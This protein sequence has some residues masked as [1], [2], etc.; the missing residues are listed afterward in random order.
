[1]RL[2]WQ[3]KAETARPTLGCAKV[4]RHQRRK[5]CQ[6]WGSSCAR[7][8]AVALF[9]SATCTAGGAGGSASGSQSAGFAS[10]AKRLPVWVARQRGLHTAM[11]AAPLPRRLQTAAACRSWHGASCGMQQQ[12]ADSHHPRQPLT[13]PQRHDTPIQGAPPN[14]KGSSG[15]GEAPTH[16]P[17]ASPPQ[18]AAPPQP[19]ASSQAWAAAQTPQPAPEGRARRASGWAGLGHGKGRATDQGCRGVAARVPVAPS[20]GTHLCLLLP[21][22]Q[23]AQH[24]REPLIQG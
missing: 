17:P 8:S 11:V 22:P 14:T 2:S 12:V 15:T 6:R 4:G 24:R 18:T 10:A 7:S 20:P 19:S 1:M 5:A 16:P 3:D 9:C 23:V 13:P 21:Q